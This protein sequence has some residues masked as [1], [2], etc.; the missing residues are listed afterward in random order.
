MNPVGDKRQGAAEGEKPRAVRNSM[1][2]SASFEKPLSLSEPSSPGSY[3]PRGI[4]LRLFLTCW[5]LYGLHFSPY[6]YRE[7]YLTMSLAEQHTVHV[8]QYVDLH[9]DLFIMPGH[10]SFVGTNPGTSLLAAIPYWLSLPLVNRIAPVRPP[11]TREE[12]SAVYNESHTDRVAFYEKVRE[13]GLDVRLGAAAMI[14]S[15]FFMAPFTALGVVVMFLLFE[16]FGLSRNQSLWFSLLFAFGTP[17]FFRTATL[18]L[19]LVVALLGLF[20][21]ALLWWPEGRDLEMEPL[22]YFGAGFLAGWAVLTDYTGVI[23]VSTLGLFAL[24][25]QIKKKTFWPAVRGSVW[26]LAGALLPVAFLLFWQAHYYGN[27]W[28]P[29]QFHMPKKY[30]MGYRTDRGFGWPVPSAL[31]ALLFDPLYGLL[32]FSPILTLALYH[33]VL[34]RRRIGK[35]PGSVATFAWSFFVALWVF[36]SCIEYTLRFQYQD[37]VR[38]MVPVV[39]FLFLLVADVLTNLPRAVTYL[40]SLAAVVEIWCLAMVREDPLESILRVLLQGFQLPWLTTLVKTASQ[41]FPDLIGGASPLPLFVF[42][43]VLIWGIWAIRNPWQ[44]LGSPEREM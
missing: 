25:L 13:R 22:R 4:K 30:Y 43:G 37:G 15:C 28:L 17:M 14:T 44:K 21:F 36:C 29:V 7:L 20:S 24:A 19:N 10:G 12:I 23:T 40:V 18:S 2:N 6:V 41:Y 9:S 39:P 26:F 1:L 31:W 3:S 11:K 32:V 42:C 34:L 38:Y 8:D 5:L 35:V 16:R 33:I 27:P